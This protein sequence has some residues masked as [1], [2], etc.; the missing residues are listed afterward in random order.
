MQSLRSR[1]FVILALATGL[2]WAF[3]AGWIWLSTRAEVERVLDARLMEAARM[4]SSLIETRE[5]GTAVASLDRT[6]A[7]MPPSHTP[8]DRQISCQIWSLNGELIGR[9]DGAP[10]SRL[11]DHPTGFAERVVD[12][13]TWRVFAVRSAETGVEV[14]VGDSLEV[15]ARLVRDM[16]TGLL[17]PMI[18][19]APALALIIWFAVQRGMRPLDELAGTLAY[20]ENPDTAL[21]KLERLVG[22]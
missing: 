15:R 12:G 3:A 13:E 19:I 6:L 14:L 2:V 21:A 7:P 8:Y 22:I 1:L 5:I 9:S 18:L 17:L 16:V 10:A 11:S 20:G 4:V